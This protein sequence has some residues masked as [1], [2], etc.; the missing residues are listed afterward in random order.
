MDGLYVLPKMKSPDHV[1]PAEIDGARVVEWAWSGDLPFGE[2]PGAESPEIFGLAIATY[3][4]CEFYRFSC[5]RDWETQQD[6]LYD[7]IDEAKQQLPDQ[8]RKVEANWRKLS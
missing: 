8:Y 3:D 7:S 4:D 1:P 5:D 6:G 2:V